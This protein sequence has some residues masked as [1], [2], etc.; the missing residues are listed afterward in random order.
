MTDMEQSLADGRLIDYWK[1]E[2]HFEC[3]QVSHI[4][5]ICDKVSFYVDIKDWKT[6]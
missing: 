3:V 4:R 2:D 1:R 5:D 6:V